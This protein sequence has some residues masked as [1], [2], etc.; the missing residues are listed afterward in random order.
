MHPI[1]LLSVLAAVLVPPLLLGCGAAPPRTMSG[2][3][4]V[5]VPASEAGISD[6]RARFR[7]I[8]CAV[9]AARPDTA[10]PRP[11]ADRD[12]A[13]DRPANCDRFLQRLDG[14]S[15]ASGAAVHLGPPR[16]R[17]RVLVVPGFGSDCFAGIA[18]VLADAE[19]ALG[20]AGYPASSVPVRGLGSTA[21][22]A[23]IVR[24]AVM[25]ADLRDDE[26]ILL[27]GYSKGAIDILETVASYPEVLPRIAAVASLAGAVGG[28]PLADT[29]D[30]GFAKSVD[31]LPG[32]R[33]QPSDHGA[34]ASLKRD[35]RQRWLAEHP[36]PESLPAFS[37]GAFT[38]REKVSLPLRPYWDRLARLDPRNDGQIVFHDQILPGSALLGYADADHWSIALSLARDH[39]VLSNVLEVEDF[40]RVAFVEAIVRHVEEQL[41]ARSEG[42]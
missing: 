20:E 3:P 19:R 6:Q 28:S 42:R 2:P 4:L 37:V 16:L 25:S 10:L 33:C 39:P 29:E 7:E 35:V 26:R 24:D 13:P 17:L 34:V 5:L 14:E 36:L 18:P 32:T 41:L 9:L 30:E 15:A 12:S 27:L 21:S 8:F 38:S 31:R 11:D 40:P 23:T 1:A 22:N